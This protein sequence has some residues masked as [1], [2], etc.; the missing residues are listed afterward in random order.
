MASPVIFAGAR[1]LN[2]WKVKREKVVELAAQQ[3]K[4][5]DKKAAGGKKKKGG[6]NKIGDQYNFLFPVCCFLKN[7]M[8]GARSTGDLAC[9]GAR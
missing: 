3:Q 7:I 4:S 6:K 2:G 1:N 8:Y 5:Q 9:G